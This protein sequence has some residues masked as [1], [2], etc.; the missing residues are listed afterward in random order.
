MKND[1]PSRHDPK[2]YLFDMLES[3]RKIREYTE[4]MTFEE[5]WESSATRDAVALRMAMIGEA[6][7]GVDAK[8]EK[9]LPAIP[10]DNIRG[11][12][13]RI[14]HDYG[15]INF[16]VVWKIA[17]EDILPLIERLESALASE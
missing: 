11:L 6:A 10:F 17:R 8:T 3:A 12:R 2:A 7:K 13:N 1:R 5:F 14:V 15:A 16:R 9:K 4:D